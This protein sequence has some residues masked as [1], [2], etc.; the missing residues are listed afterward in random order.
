MFALK[1][2]F[3]LRYHRDVPRSIHVPL[4]KL[5]GI[6]FA[7]I[8]DHAPG[9]VMAVIE[10]DDALLD[11]LFGDYAPEYRQLVQDRES[12]WKELMRFDEELVLV[13]V[14]AEANDEG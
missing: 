11:E 3:Y 13:S 6:D 2:S 10:K 4:D 9:M 7:G 14:G 1:F 8:D 12:N 5:V